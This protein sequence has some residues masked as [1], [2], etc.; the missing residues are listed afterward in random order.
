MGYVQGM[1]DLLAP[2]LVVL[3]NGE[4]WGS[5]LG[6]CPEWCRVRL[7]KTGEGKRTARAGQVKLAANPTPWATGHPLCSGVLGSPAPWPHCRLPSDQLA[8]SCFSHLM[9]RMSQNFPSGGAMDTH[10]ANMRS[11]IQVRAVA[12]C[13]H[14][15]R[16]YW[17]SPSSTGRPW[18][19][20]STNYFMYK[21]N[22][23]HFRNIL[24][25]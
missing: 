5:G 15:T 20:N 9:K 14:L 17:A 22:F 1:C 23:S 16:H 10:F 4:R 3:D 8:Y 21:L 19:G 18:S 24:F 6:A 13:G 7:T 11:L 25:F 2:L 12:A